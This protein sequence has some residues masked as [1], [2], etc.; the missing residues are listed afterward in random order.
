M[1]SRIVLVILAA[2]FIASPATAVDVEVAGEINIGGVWL[3]GFFKQKK[4]D[5]VQVRYQRDNRWQEEWISPEHWRDQPRAGVTVQVYSGNA[6]VQATVV[7]VE[8]GRYLCRY[9]GREAWFAPGA[10]RPYTA[11]AVQ[12]TVTVGATGRALWNDKWYDATVLEV[13]GDRVQVRYNEFG[14]KY[15][16]WITLDRWKSG[17]PVAASRIG[18][19]V[20][21]NH[22]GTWISARIAQEQGGRYLCRWPGGEG[23]FGEGQWRAAE[24]SVSVSVQVGARGHA[25]WK[26]NWYNATVIKVEAGKAYV[27]YDDYGDKYHDWISFDRWRPVAAPAPTSVGVEVLVNNGGVWVKATVIQE[28]D[29]RYLC[30][31]AGGEGW[32]GA[33][34]W[35]PVE[36]AAAVTITVGTTGQAFWNDKWY[37]ATILK[38][39]G[40]RVYVRYDDYGDKYNDWI[41]L[42]RWRNPGIEPRRR[43][44]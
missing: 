30:R 5:K 4:R 23:W 40:E 35:K 31:W 14:D 32:F 12:V 24:P 43:I 17:A 36:R 44:D 33:G 42:D 37:K 8:T 38:V 26:D 29:G 34:Q 21:V 15:N 18:I 39:E 19:E 22:N 1:A 10:W 11:P 7:R 28:R 16:E 3:S 13:R 41:P 27:R 9:D 6:W 25:W 20:Q 2:A